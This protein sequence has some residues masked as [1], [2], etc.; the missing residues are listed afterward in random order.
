MRRKNESLAEILIKAPW[1][2]SIIVAALVF[3]GMRWAF[4]AYLSDKPSTAALSHGIAN[5]AP[6]GALFFLLIAGLSA[7]Y[8]KKRRALVDN[9]TSLQNLRDLHWQDFEWMIAESYRRQGYTADVAISGGADGGVDVVLRKSD[10]TVFVQCKQ[11]KTSSVGSP[12]IRDLYGAMNKARAARGIVITSGRFTKDAIDFATGIPIEL[13]DG[14]KL[15][16]LLQGVQRPKGSPATA[17][18]ASPI[19]NASPSCPTCGSAMVERVALR[20]KNA[21]NKFWGCSEYPKCRGTLPQP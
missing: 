3:A 14:E 15:L 5:I 2:V 20:G 4:P 16:E 9:Q 6:F 13:V 7:L 17:Q 8:Q 12:V 11:W 1:W 18:P 19:A 10:Q 21:G